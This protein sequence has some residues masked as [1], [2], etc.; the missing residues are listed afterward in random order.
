MVTRT[1]A[2]HLER[3]S[4]VNKELEINIYPPCSHNKHREVH[5]LQPKIQLLGLA[6]P[7]H[8][9]TKTLIKKQ[10][11]KLRNKKIHC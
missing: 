11:G 3:P 5:F 4:P 2:L 1:Q 8:I 10:K 9:A 6:I 7:Q